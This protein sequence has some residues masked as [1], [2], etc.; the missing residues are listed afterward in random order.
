MEQVVDDEISVNI[1]SC[2]HWVG[3]ERKNYGSFREEK[4]SGY[5]N[6]ADCVKGIG[7]GHGDGV[8]SSNLTGYT[9]GD[10]NGS[11]Y[12]NGYGNGEGYGFN[13]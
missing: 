5:G 8:I 10:G 4:G 9:D 6:S 3:N 7:K 2:F 12:G 13:F 1:F 11:G